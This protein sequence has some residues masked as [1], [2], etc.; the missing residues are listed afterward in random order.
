MGRNEIVEVEYDPKQITV[1]DMSE[2]LQ[3]QSSFY[4]VIAQSSSEYTETKKHLPDSDLT[5]NSSTPHFV[6]SKYALRLRYPELLELGLSEQQMMKLNS[7]SY[8]GGPMPDVLTESQKTK[9]QK[10]QQ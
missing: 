6:E 7:W 4:S 3:R 2:A 5:L 8:F 1:Q 10:L 9:L